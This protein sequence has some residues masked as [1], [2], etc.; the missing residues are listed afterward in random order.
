MFFSLYNS[1]TLSYTPTCV[2]ML[3]VFA[4]YFVTIVV[5]AGLYLTVNKVGVYYGDS[6]NGE[7]LLS[8]EAE[9]GSLSLGVGASDVGVS[10]F[11]GMDINNHMEGKCTRSHMSEC[12][13]DVSLIGVSSLNEF[14]LYT[15]PCLQW[16]RLDMAPQTTTLASVGLLLSSCFFR[17]F[18][19]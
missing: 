9:E 19:P 7:N 18:Q 10:S 12:R 13:L 17:S 2:L 8:L 6:T 5:F 16:Q 1:D 3:G 4:A 14:Q 15:F 11:C